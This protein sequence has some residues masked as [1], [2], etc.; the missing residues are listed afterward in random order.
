MFVASYVPRVRRATI[1]DVPVHRTGRDDGKNEG[2]GWVVFTSPYERTLMWPFALIL[3]VALLRGDCQDQ[4]K[5]PHQSPS[6]GD[7]NTTHPLP[8]IFAIVSARSVN[9]RINYSCRPDART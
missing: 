4:G 5:W 7:V 6:Y 2:Q 3:T 1:V 9:R 8:F